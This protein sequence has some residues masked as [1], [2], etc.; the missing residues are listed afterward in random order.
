MR[1]T[2]GLYITLTVSLSLLA[3]ILVLG[4]IFDLQISQ[5]LADLTV[6]KYLSENLFAI[7]FESIGENV[8]YLILLCAFAILFHY[9]YNFSLSKKWKNWFVLV[10][11]CV[12]SG[13]FSF[14]GLY[15]T[16]GYLATYTNFGLDIYL[17]GFWGIASIFGF[18]SVFVMIVFFIFGKLKKETITSLTGF[19]LAVVIVAAISNGI[20]QGS[21]LIFDRARYRAMVYEGYTDFEYY[22]HWFQI[23]SNKFASVSVFASDFFRSFPSGHTCAAASSFL[24]ILLPEFSSKFN[25]KKWKIFLHFIATVYTLTVAI[26]RI[27]A[28]AHFFMDVFVGGMTTIILVYIIKWFF[29]DKLKVFE[30]NKEN[31]F[32]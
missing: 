10:T 25:T 18:S 7:I 19:A 1:K 3:I 16:M 26:S 29:V 24:I 32:Q 27:I 6:G 31:I 30:K 11:I 21:K 5:S 22:T 20:V 17:R 9:F 8:L 14:Y 23:N 13:I 28:G 2:R 15:K 12:L 4:T